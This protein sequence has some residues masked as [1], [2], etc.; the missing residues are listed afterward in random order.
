M[1]AQSFSSSS[2]TFISRNRSVLYGGVATAILIVVMT[3]MVALLQMRQQTEM[4]T[5]LTTQNLAKLM[6]QTYDGL[7]DTIDVALLA[8]A[9]EISRQMSAGNTD[10]QSITRFLVR[11]QERLPHVAYLRATN[12]RGDVIYGPAIL[13]PPHNNSDREYFVRLR[14]DPN[15]GLF[16]SKPLLGRIE[17]KWVWLFARRINRPD[18]SFG[19]VVYAGIFV[20]L[21]DEM[22]ARIT[23]DTGGVAT[24]RDAELGLIARHVFQGKNP[25]PPGDK[26]IAT[27]FADALKANP[28]EGTYV[29]G[30]T[31][32]DN[33][34][35]TQSYRR[36]AKYGFYVNVGI[37]RDAALG[38]WR[39]E[40]KIVA[41]LVAAFTWVL[42][43]FS[44]HIRRAWLRQEQDMA[45]LHEAQEIA[46]FGHYTY[47]LRTGRWTSS[48][49]LDGIFGIGSDYPRDVQHWLELIVAD[50]RPEMQAYLNTVIEQGLPFDREYR[51]FRP[52]DGEERWVHGKGKLKLDVQG[53]PLVL[54]GAIQDITERKLAEQKLEDSEL[55]L[56]TI[57]E[58]E[59][60]CVKLLAADGTLLHMNRAGLDMIDADSPEQVVG[61]KVQGI[62]A[63]GYQKA[64]M[65]L[66]RRVFEGESGNL[67]FEVVGLMGTHRWLDTHAVPLL[68]SQG[69]ITALLG[70]TR[71]ITERKQAEQQLRIAAIAFESQ[72][73][74][75][76]TD[77][78]NVIL[79]VNQAF[80]DITGY[81]VEDAVGQTPRLL[82]SG[83]H[84]AAFYAAMWEGIRRNGAWQGEIWN[85]RKNG[86]EYPE[87]LT[88]T[89]VKGNAGETT[90]YVATL[91]DM[92]ARKA[93]EEEIRH[94]AFYSPLTHL[95]NRRLLL[96]RLQQSLASSTRNEREGALLFIDL[97]NFKFLN[98][99]FG[100]AVGDLLLQEVARRLGT[101]VREGDT[102]AHLGGDE[103]VVMLEDLSENSQEAAAQTET[104]GEKILA[105][106]SQPYQLAGHTPRS[107]ASIGVSLFGAQRE[108]VDEILKRADLAMSQAKAA[109][110][111]TL[112]FFDPEIQTA[113]TTRIALESEL[114]QGVEENQFLLHYQAQI[115]DEGH[116]TGAEV[117][118]RWRHPRRGLVSPAEFIPLAEATGLILPLGHWVLET[119]CA[120]LAAWAF[121]KEMADLSLAVNVSARQ[122]RHPDFVEQVLAVLDHTG[123]NPHKLK[124]ELTESLMLDNVEDI[125]AKM[126]AL[127]A[128]G[129]RF[130]LDDFGTG[131]SSLTYL[132]RLPLFQ[133]KIDQSFV[134]DVLTDPNDA[135]I[136]RT[137]V[138]LAQSL[139]L[140]VI[141][142]GVETYA[143]RDFL[144]LNGCPAYQGYLFSRPV[145]LEAFERLL[146][147][148][149]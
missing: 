1:Q 74:M 25:A 91:T 96:D 66:T 68:D 131:Y 101:C 128:H 135:A 124:L 10:R 148:S 65:A 19:G 102:V 12:E 73:G 3:A 18:G 72:E 11:Q 136:A 22:L 133:L 70:L 54:V 80:T 6:E 5:A 37:S 7:T 107:T 51:I 40:A 123:A 28:R 57:I 110:H 44:W 17:H 143:Q 42:L 71:D 20:D 59:P 41:G 69:N 26:K 38:V 147:T 145:P 109:G 126:T 125:I 139:G 86:E 97:D 79:R 149:T 120:Q 76:I 13:S 100:Y 95:P 64:F 60:E 4:R 105:M 119:A 33:I 27:P 46:S 90:H 14:D 114:R 53:N 129:L 108:S 98:D 9:D 88:I 141:A 62:I 89:A 8:S 61:R 117:L 93:A 43:I 50:S 92:T 82:K 144:A 45:A 21:I 112:R 116:L 35:R 24:L 48:E 84:D 132:K 56:K 118:V 16:I 81:S 58:T 115:D 63:P 127:K 75:V 99:T 134:R 87:W 122:F 15:A 32:I 83:R 47:D 36:S 140:S 23:L 29:S 55:R 94:L 67:E 103:F 104:V 142:E 130:S 138:A 78:E 52:N 30:A 49:I 34:N 31:S 77:A 106:L 137:I 121:R 111:N 2:S 113:I 146:K 39:K 85:R